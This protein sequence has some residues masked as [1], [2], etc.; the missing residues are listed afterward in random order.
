MLTRIRS[1]LS[2][3]RGTDPELCLAKKGGWE[4]AQLCIIIIFSG[5]ESEDFGGVFHFMANEP[6]PRHQPHKDDSETRHTR[7]RPLVKAL[8][9]ILPASKPQ[10]HDLSLTALYLELKESLF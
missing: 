10:P 3:S 7:V 5:S 2:L 8:S 6:Q 9:P 1:S 4:M